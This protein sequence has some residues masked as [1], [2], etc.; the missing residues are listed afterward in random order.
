[1]TTGSV[2][3]FAVRSAIALRYLRSGGS[4]P[5]EIVESDGERV[6][7]GP[8]LIEYLP[9]PDNPFHARIHT[10]GDAIDLWIEGLGWYRVDPGAGRVEVPAGVDEIAREERLWGIPTSLC[11]IARGDHPLHAATVEVEGRALLLAGPGRHGKTTLAAASH[12][13]G[14]RL[15]SEDATICRPGATP[16]VVPGPALLRLRRD[17]Y[18]R[19][20]VPDVELVGEDPDRLHLAISRDRRG[21]TEP[22]PIAGLVLLGVGDEM[23][24]ERVDAT[25]AIQQLWHLSFWLPGD[26]GRANAFA[27]VADLASR[28]P[29]WRLTRPMRY[30]TLDVVL[31][32]LER[33]AIG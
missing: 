12:A 3:G 6:P 19:L 22:V 20:H 7:D 30:E 32:E 31:E 10:D 23:H 27:R 14:F 15:L 1:M 17:S 33:L 29:V 2:A 25:S 13:H 28:V 16:T 24:A 5:L 21:T 18:E 8:L 4:E 9:R 26:E 11:A